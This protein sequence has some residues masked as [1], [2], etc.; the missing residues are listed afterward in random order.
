[1]FTK[2]IIVTYPSAIHLYQILLEEVLTKDPQ[3]PNV[4]YT[5]KEYGRH[6]N[7]LILS[8]PLRGTLDYVSSEFEKKLKPR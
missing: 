2:P 5:F 6:R 4:D 7:Y 3:K 1:M 8:S